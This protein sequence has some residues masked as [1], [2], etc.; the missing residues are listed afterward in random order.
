MR[1][2]PGGLVLGRAAALRPLRHSDRLAGRALRGVLGPRIAFARPARRSCT[3][4]PAARSSALEGA[5]P[6]RARRPRP[7]SWDVGCRPRAGRRMVSRSSPATATARGG[8]GA[9]RGPSRAA[10]GRGGGPAGGGRP[11]PRGAPPP[12]GRPRGS[13]AARKGPRR[14]PRAGA[15]RAGPPSWGG[16]THGRRDHERGRVRRQAGGGRGGGGG[17]GAG[18]PGRALTSR[19]IR[20]AQ[21]PVPTGVRR[22]P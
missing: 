13:G 17:A 9:H 19:G 8:G 6:A 14:P 5:R 16:P 15:R 18:P 11:R 1:A 21:T 4:R 3:T 10:A 22:R 7:P 2:V 12:P 20:H